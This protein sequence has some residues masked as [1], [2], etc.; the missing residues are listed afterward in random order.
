MKRFSKVFLI[1]ILL[2]S[3][4]LSGCSLAGCSLGPR[5][6]QAGPKNELT[7]EWWGVYKDSD[8]FSRQI[9]R[10]EEKYTNI[11]I[12]YTQKDPATYEQEL[13]DSLAANQ[14][15]DIA[16]IK[17]DWFPKHK[18]KLSPIELKPE[19]AENFRNSYL[20]V[21]SDLVLEDNKLYGVPLDID[22]LGLFYNED[23]LSNLRLRRPPATWEQFNSYIR[24][25]TK[26]KGNKI[27]RAGAAIGTSKNIDHS[28]DILL[29]MMLQN[30]TEITSSDLQS[31]IFHTTVET[32]TGQPIYTGRKALQL[33][34]SYANPRKNIYTWNSKMDQAWLAFAEGKVA[35]I[36]D[37]YSRKEDLYNRNPQLDYEFANVPQIKNAEPEDK[38]D[39]AHFWANCVTN[40]T[41]DQ[42]W[43][44]LF[45]QTL[46]QNMADSSLKKQA[47][48]YDKTTIG[49]RIFW[50]QGLIAK[51]IYKGKD[52]EE[53]NRVFRNMITNV[54]TRKQDIRTAIDTAAARITEI[55]KNSL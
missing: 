18:D 44:W 26:R 10:F 21:V 8:Y 54:V 47:D 37:Y 49:K 33:Y 7:L 29:L 48:R 15:P 39:I 25:L 31:A 28:E 13:V 45:T 32:A 34:T 20:P 17:E 52:P 24:K 11:K 42:Y 1:I 41:R 22:V 40:N 36:F 55:Y 4:S 14:G 19:E 3:F 23:M 35:M 46:A 27:I 16:M 53:F 12:N 43:S 6:K 51:S 9:T 2:G 5:K 50:G 38:R 30:G